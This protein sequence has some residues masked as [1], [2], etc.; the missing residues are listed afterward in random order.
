[1]NDYDERERQRAAEEI[2]ARQALHDIGTAYNQLQHCG[3]VEFRSEAPLYEIGLLLLK[4]GIPVNDPCPR[5]SQSIEPLTVESAE[6][7]SYDHEWSD[8][9]HKYV[10][11]PR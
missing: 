1:M 6:A 10:R 8:T 2:A 5:E 3:G 11:K 4:A 9:E 7:Q